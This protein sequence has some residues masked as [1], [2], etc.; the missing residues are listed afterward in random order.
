VRFGY[1][2]AA[3]EGFSRVEVARVTAGVRFDLA[4]SVVLK[5]EWLFNQER[6]GAPHAANDVRAISVVFI[7]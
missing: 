3:F 1:R 4:E 2:R 6:S 5:G 7:W